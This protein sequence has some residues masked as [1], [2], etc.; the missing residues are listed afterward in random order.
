MVGDRDMPRVTLNYDLG[1]E[2]FLLWISSQR[3]DLYTKN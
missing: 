1:Y 2:K 3:Q